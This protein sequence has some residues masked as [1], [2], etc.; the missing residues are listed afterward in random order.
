M[1]A[2]TREEEDQQLVRNLLNCPTIAVSPHACSA[3]RVSA[4]HLLA[5]QLG[6]QIPHL[7][8]RRALHR[9]QM[10][11]WVSA[12]HSSA[13]ALGC[14]YTLSPC[15]APREE[16]TRALFSPAGFLWVLLIITLCFACAGS[17]MRGACKPLEGS[18]R[19]IPE[20]PCHFQGIC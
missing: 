1:T 12:P 14:S 7:C 9:N 4:P 5:R 11:S 6:I 18:I 13:W 19:S 10:G 3:G 15:A 16:E 2:E 20:A 8:Y 17:R